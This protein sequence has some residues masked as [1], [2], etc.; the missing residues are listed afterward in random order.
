MDFVTTQGFANSICRVREGCSVNTGHSIELV[1]CDDPRTLAV[2]IGGTGIKTMVLDE[3]GHPLM[4]RLREPTPKP[5]TPEAV[6]ETIAALAGRSGDYERVAVGFPGVVRRGIVESAPNL[7]PS[8]AGFP[9]AERLACRLNHPVRVAN[10][11]DI[12]GFG[13]IRGEGIE[14]VITLGT[15][16]GSAM[17]ADGILVPNLEL[18]HHPFE[19]GKTYEDWLGQRS[20]EKTGEEACNAKLGDAIA[21]L[22]RIFNF[23][24]LYIGGGNSRLLDTKKLPGD[25]EVVANVSGLLGGIAL[26]TDLNGT[27]LIRSPNAEGAHCLLEPRVVPLAA[28]RQAAS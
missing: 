12:Q 15:G 22:R 7:D 23:D 18:A 5:A 6:L 16:M 25:V 13:A 3:F 24:R 11:A 4:E 2:D 8:F 10:D 21:L 28:E 9:F 19:D 20:L 14:M 27:R 1:P 17:F 26:W